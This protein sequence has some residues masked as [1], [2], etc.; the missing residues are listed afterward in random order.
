[1]SA[2]I[3]KGIRDAAS[4]PEVFG[5]LPPFDEADPGPHVCS[6]RP[7]RPGWALYMGKGWKRRERR[8]ILGGRESCA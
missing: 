6:P 5:L 3:I 8:L 2:R 7:L 1:M 4:P